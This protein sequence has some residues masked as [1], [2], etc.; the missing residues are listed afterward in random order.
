MSGPRTPTKGRRVGH[1]GAGAEAMNECLRS[2]PSRA[3]RAGAAPVR[4]RRGHWVAPEDCAARADSA[5][6]G[7]HLQ[8]EGL[9]LVLTWPDATCVRLTSIRDTHDGVRGVL[10]VSQGAQRLSWG[11]LELSSMQT[12]EAW[13][14]RLAA[15]APALPWGEYLEESAFR[16]TQAARE[17]EPLVTLTG[18]ITAPARV[19]MPGLLYEGEPTEVHADGDTGKSLFLTAVLTAGAGNISLPCGLRATRPLRAA[20]LDWETSKDTV[21]ARVGLL[22]AG[23]GIDPPP[24][25]YKRMKRR[26]VDE[27]PARVAEFARRGINAIGIDSLMFAAGGSDGAAFHEPI[28]AFYTALGLFAPAAVIVLN[29]VTNADARNRGSARPFGGAFAYNGPRLI[30]EA[31][32]QGR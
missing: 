20:Y 24:I 1:G 8:R 28:T 27:A 15:A 23:L 31:K 18:V 14:K 29:H 26:P 21:D 2:E 6:T 12:R 22:A 30:W 3:H 11:R 9:D 4:P 13:R 10:T 17:G 5:T 7:P 25:L 32:R 16:L 19:L